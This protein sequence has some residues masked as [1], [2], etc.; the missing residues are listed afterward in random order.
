MLQLFGRFTGGRFLGFGGSLLGCLGFGFCR[1]GLF[2]LLGRGEKRSDRKAYALF[3]KVALGDLSLN[4]LADRQEIGYVV[5]ALIGYL[6]DVDKA[7]D[8]GDNL[9]EGAEIGDRDYLSLDNLP[10]LVISL[11]DI[12]GIVRLLL[13]NQRDLA[14]FVVDILD[15]DLDVI[16]YGD[17]FGGVSDSPRLDRPF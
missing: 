11:E 3:L 14:G 9:R 16:A 10:E 12:P 15:G 17:D 5:D 8:S 6:G 7:V 1:N 4:R 13:V 2:G